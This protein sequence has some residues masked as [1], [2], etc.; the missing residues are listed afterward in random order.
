VA[1]IAASCYDRPHD[2]EFGPV[3]SLL[4]KKRLGKCIFHGGEEDAEV[5]KCGAIS[6]YWTRA[7]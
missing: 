7:N 4:V 1:I 6:R 5:G 2:V 3:E